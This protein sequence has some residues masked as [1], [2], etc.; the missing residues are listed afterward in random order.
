[1]THTAALAVSLALLALLVAVV[2]PVV[3]DLL[4]AAGEVAG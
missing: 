2:G 1:M 4:A 3:A